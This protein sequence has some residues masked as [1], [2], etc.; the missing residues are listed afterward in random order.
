MRTLQA[1]IGQ[2]VLTET[3]KIDKTQIE[4]VLKDPGFRVGFEFEFVGVNAVDL[5][6]DDLGEAPIDFDGFAIAQDNPF[7][8]QVLSAIAPYVAH[9]IGIGPEMLAVIADG[10]DVDHS[11]W[12]LKTDSSLYLV[13]DH[14][15]DRSGAAGSPYSDIG[16]ELTTP[17]LPLREGL[18]ALY[19]IADLIGSF[20]YG[21]MVFQT[22]H[23]CSLH[24]NLSHVGMK[25]R[26][27]D[28][29]KLAFLIG[30][31]HYL[32]QFQRQANKYAAPIL[33]NL[34]NRLRSILNQWGT[35]D[36]ETQKLLM[37]AYVHELETL[38]LNNWKTADVLT[39]IQ[40]YI[41]AEHK[42]SVNFEHLE[43]DNPY[44]EFRMAG[45]VAYENRMDTVVKMVLRFAALLLIA[46]M[47]E[48]YMRE[49]LTKVYKMI[50][51][52]VGRQQTNRPAVD[53][54]KAMNQARIYLRSILAGPARQVVMKLETKAVSKLLTQDDAY[55]LLYLMRLAIDKGLAQNP[56]VLKG[57]G[58]VLHDVLKMQPDA[59]LMLL[60]ATMKLFSHGILR[61]SDMASQRNVS[62]YE[63]VD[64]DKVQ[65]VAG[66]S[67][68]KVGTKVSVPTVRKEKTPDRTAEIVKTLQRM[69]KSLG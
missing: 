46:L 47:P 52:I 11:K 19:K 24:I 23:R 20:R 57:L 40:Q 10:D 13:G 49:Y 1:L 9:Q 62:G 16:L 56:Q 15:F 51:S 3:V 26:K 59:V 31:E 17:I 63:L 34:A 8:S 22:T 33:H 39:A 35:G 14:P 45:N 7:V 41:P 18:E 6:Q 12:N 42:M 2:P 55:W 68:P 29:A 69:V 28:F 48:A 50:A 53:P 67:Y 37:R 61:D 4:R 30:D 43:S 64:A 44:V 54:H 21:R 38:R 32:G 58:I 5:L 65:K 60:R 27:L 36:E 66:L 25:S